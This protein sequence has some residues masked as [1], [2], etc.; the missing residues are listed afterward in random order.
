MS[1]V[2]YEDHSAFV[3]SGQRAAIKDV[4]TDDSLGRSSLDK[5]MDP[6]R[7]FHV[8][9]CMKSSLFDGFRRR[10]RVVLVYF[11]GH[12][13]LFKSNPGTD[14]PVAADHS[15]HTALAM[16]RKGVSDL[17][18]VLGLSVKEAPVA[19][20]VLEYEGLVFFVFGKYMFQHSRM[21]SIGS[22]QN[23]APDSQAVGKS[24]F[25]SIVC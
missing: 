6:T 3:P 17:E 9:E 12:L 13:S 2:S 19:D 20:G 24:N 16:N 18:R 25:H 5:V 11:R 4:G 14:V 8:P 21:D 7:V 10:R 22:Y 1:G 23:V 15:K